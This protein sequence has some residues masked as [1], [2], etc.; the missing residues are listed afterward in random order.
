[1]VVT[2]AQRCLAGTGCRRQGRFRSSAGYGVRD[3]REAVA[4]VGDAPAVLTTL[5]LV[6]RG[7]G[8]NLAKFADMQNRKPATVSCQQCGYTALY[9]GKTSMLGNILDFFVGG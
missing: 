9:K 7:G 6:L 3:R 5:A 4:H 8:G 1:M 2:L